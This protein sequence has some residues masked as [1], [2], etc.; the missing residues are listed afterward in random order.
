MIGKKLGYENHFE[1][2]KYR[3]DDILKSAISYQDQHLSYQTTKL[4]YI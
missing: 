1:T 3:T 2:K 4:K